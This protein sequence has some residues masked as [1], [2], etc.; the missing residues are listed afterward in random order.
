MRDVEPLD[1]VELAEDV[2]EGALA[3]ID[4]H[5]RAHADR[6]LAPE[7]VG[8]AHDDVARPGVAGDGG[9]HEADRPRPADQHVLA[10]D[11]EG[12]GGVDRVAERV[13][14]RGDLRVDAGPVVPD[15]GHRQDHVLGERAVAADA[16]TDRLGAQVASPGQAVAAASAHDVA[17]AAARGRPA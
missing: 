9:R 6:Q 3:R 8:L 5:R 1:H 12:E 7:G 15:V 13:E 16:E 17:L 2:R 4:G 11:R 10:E 14:D